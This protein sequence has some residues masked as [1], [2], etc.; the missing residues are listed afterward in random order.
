MRIFAKM[1][2]YNKTRLSFMRP[3]LTASVL[4]ACSAWSFSALSDNLADVYQA[5]VENDPMMRAAEAEFRANTEAKNLARA[6]LLPQLSLNANVGYADSETKPKKSEH[7]FLKSDDKGREFSVGLTLQ[8]QLLNMSSWYTFKGG[9]ELSKQAEIKFL[10]NQQDLI[11]RTVQAYFEVLRAESN[12]ASSVAEE[13]A[14]KQQLDQ[15]QQRFD[16]GL[17]A[18]TDV[19]EAQAAYDMA[20]VGLIAN[21]GHLQIAYQALSVLT[22]KN[23]DSIDSLAQ[24]FP[25]VSPEPADMQEWVNK[26]LLNNPKILLAESNVSAA[27]YQAKAAKADHYPTIALQA[28]IRKANT[29]GDRLMFGQNLKNL[30]A[31]SDSWQVGVGLSMPLYSGGGVGAKRRQAYAQYDMAKE[32]TVGTERVITQQTRSQFITALTSMQTVS[33]RK[34]AIVSADSALD[35]IQSG[36]D[37]GTRNIVD[38]LNAQRNLFAAERDYHNARYD[39]INSMIELKYLAGTLSPEDINHLSQWLTANN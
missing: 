19:N 35:A 11:S 8:Q 23:Y 26:S 30:E 18:I 15:M 36:Y 29:K 12:L 7:D 20:N 10:D 17:V 16:V 3:L 32:N 21:K 24:D 2:H 31:D 4:L 37:V 6:A 22:G 9:K 5:A 38:V 33:A 14:M 25:V 1:A 13:K 39:Y 34:Q 27:E 28:N